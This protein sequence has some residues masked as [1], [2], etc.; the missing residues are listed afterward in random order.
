MQ[1]TWKDVKGFE[2]LYQVSDMGH[3]RS[4]D[5][6]V[7][8]PDG[9]AVFYHGRVLKPC[10]APYLHVGLSRL[11]E[12]TQRRVHRLVAEAFLPNPDGLPCI[13]HIDCD[14][15]NN[16]ADN[17][18][19]CTHAQNTQFAKDN[20]RLRNGNYKT[21]PQ[22]TREQW[23]MHRRKPIVR[24]DGQRYACC[25]DAAKEL[26]VTYGA[27]MHVLRGIS[28]TCRGYSFCYA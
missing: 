14:K 4:L 22:K 10:G 17:L 15:T 26:G 28:A 19:W 20:G 27:V 12:T 9:T 21:W 7:K 13:D 25:A 8:R 23:S 6:Y 1:E 5:H 2:G 16:R 11:G 18:R 24:S 3:V